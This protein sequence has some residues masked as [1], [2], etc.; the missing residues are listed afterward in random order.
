MQITSLIKNENYN[1]VISEISEK[2][3]NF[4]FPKIKEIEK[5]SS[6]EFIRDICILLKHYDKDKFASYALETK[7]IAGSRPKR[8]PMLRKSKQSISIWKS[9]NEL[10]KVDRVVNELNDIAS[11]VDNGDAL[12]KVIIITD[13]EKKYSGDEK[14][15]NQY[16]RK[17]VSENNLIWFSYDFIRDLIK[18]K[19]K[20]VNIEKYLSSKGS[21][22]ILN[23]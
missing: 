13:S 12:I 14:R 1:R 19:N 9:V 15:N 6:S 2:L 8:I 22:Y 20:K 11:F 17:I 3:E 5:G 23:K 16:V 4:L 21:I 10:E 18:Q 7:I